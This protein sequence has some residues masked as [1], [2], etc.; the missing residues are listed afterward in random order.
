MIDVIKDYLVGI[1]FKVDMGS[2]G[3][4]SRVMGDAEKVV[5]KFAGSTVTQ[6]ATAGAAVTSF[7]AIAAIGIGKFLG[8]LAKSDLEVQKF[9]RRLWTTEENAR[10]LKYTLGIMGESLEDI[11]INPEL[12]N[13]FFQLRGQAKAMQAPDELQSQLKYI[14][15]I[16]FEF[17]RMKLE[18]TY[19]MQWIGYYIYKYLEK[20]I[21]QIKLS[22]KAFNDDITKSMPNWTKNIAQVASW[23]GRLGLTIARLG[24]DFFKLMDKIPDEIKKI[25]AALLSMGL[26]LKANPITLIILGITA[27]L[28]LLED[29]YTYLDGGESQ[30]EGLWKWVDKFYKQLEE[31][32]LIEEY[33]DTISELFTNISDLS[34]E[35]LN[36]LDNMAKLAGSTD[37]ETAFNDGL[38]NTLKAVNELVQGISEGL[39]TITLLLSGDFE[40]AFG[41]VVQS[42][43][44]L[45]G[46]ILKGLLGQKNGESVNNFFRKI[47]NYGGYW[48]ENS[49][50]KI[51]FDNPN[52]YLFPRAN[53]ATRTVTNNLNPTFNIYGSDPNATSGAALRQMDE[54]YIRSLRGAIE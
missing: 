49:K 38:I 18:A 40:K 52:Y 43:D 2:Y 51:P 44:S 25:S 23:F 27:L 39:K 37:F 1:G 47:F 10:S 42:G 24:I 14:R 48:D 13:Q 34:K 36:L 35:I 41:G 9:A 28:L 20:P 53:S 11:A 15:S 26:L 6:F 8:G 4:V 31:T 7:G 46:G 21:T 22:L 30:F 5:S 3:Q 54:L 29:F 12:R 19:A 33:S 32:G 50:V 16:Q 45:R 17:R